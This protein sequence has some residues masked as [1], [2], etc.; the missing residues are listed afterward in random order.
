MAIN[1]A[2]AAVMSTG[3]PAGAAAC[4]AAAGAAAAAPAERPA[5]P[6]LRARPRRLPR[7][8][9]A[10]P[11]ATMRSNLVTREEPMQSWLSWLCGARR[12]GRGVRRRLGRVLL[13][14][15]LGEPHLGDVVEVAHAGH[16]P[17][18]RVLRVGAAGDRE[19]RRL[20][21]RREGWRGRRRRRR[22]RPRRRANRWPRRSAAR[23]CAGS[24]AKLAQRAL[25]V[26]AALASVLDLLLAGALDGRRTARRDAARRRPA[27]RPAP[28]PGA[29]RACSVFPLIWLPVSTSASTQRTAAPSP[30][31]TA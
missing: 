14:R 26:E 30:P 21:L 8:P 31:R 29:R 27:S 4:A 13:A 22:P 17:R 28:V 24:R 6:T 16:H 23:R 12:G 20:G 18:D 15:R 10:P 7:R 19:R 5:P 11:K 25:P 2:V 3:P 1:V 9:P